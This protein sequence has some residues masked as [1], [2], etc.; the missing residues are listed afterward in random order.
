MLLFF[1]KRTQK[2]KQREKE[3]T[4]L[5]KKLAEMEL[6]ALRAQMNPHFIFNVLNS[7]QYYISHNKNEEAQH[8]MSKFAKLVRSTLDN[9]R[10]TFISLADELSLLRLYI[11]LEKIR[12]EDRFDYEIKIGN[13]IDL[14]AVKIPN[15]LLQPYVENSIKHGF[16]G[17]E[18]K[19]FIDI[20]ILSEK[21]NIVCLIIDNGI[22]REKAALIPGA[23]KDKHSSTGTI[24]I[25]EKIE[26]L[27]QYYNYDL[28]SV[29]ED[30]KDG[31]G[32]PIG[33]KV[34]LTFPEI[35]DISDI[36]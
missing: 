32:N 24:I 10:S 16:K 7:I 15:M 22:G 26:A 30:L 27:K 14:N 35:A 12:F 31:N 8:Y 19:Y 36:V 1:V 23:E 4:F 2:I 3:R 33:T 29:T 13:D 34:I 9:S 18:A 5:N 21:E 11:D 28:S 17:K 20:S 25:K 6:K